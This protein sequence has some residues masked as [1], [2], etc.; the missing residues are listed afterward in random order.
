MELEPKFK[1]R[2]SFTIESNI[3]IFNKNQENSSSIN[4]SDVN[5][6]IKDQREQ[7]ISKRKE[8]IQN[9]H[10]KQRLLSLI[11]SNKKQYNENN[12]MNMNGTND[13]VSIEDIKDEPDPISR[14]ILIKKF[15]LSNVS[16]ININFI[17][18]HINDIKEWFKDYNKYLFDYD[19]KNIKQQIIVN[20]SIIYN[21]LSLLI[22]LDDN[23][24]IDLI[25]YDFLYNLNNFCFHYFKLQNNDENIK[26]FLYILFLLN[27]LIVVHPDEELIKATINFKD[28]IQLIYNKFFYSAKNNNSIINFQKNNIN[29]FNQCNEFELLEFSF[30]KLI[31]NCINHLHLQENDLKELISIL[32]SLCYFNKYNENNKL[33]IY[34]L[35]CLSLINH[36]FFLLNNNIYNNFLFNIGQ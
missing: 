5:F 32:L 34:C 6:T 30:V 25:D 23:P 18:N 36:S 7:L 2:E 10:K 22:D 11:D 33:L 28:I 17:K 19:N 3:N 16:Q 13:E 24:I 4:E 26:Y 8:F 20:K 29:N 12:N 31:E 15:I 21:I 35:E 9:Y 14:I 27:N 1:N